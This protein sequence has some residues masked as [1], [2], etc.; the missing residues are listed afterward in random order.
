[1]LQPILIFTIFIGLATVG[2]YFAT[3]STFSKKAARIVA[4]STFLFLLALGAGIVWLI[5]SAGGG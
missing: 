4:V 2:S 1:M 5:R 3:A